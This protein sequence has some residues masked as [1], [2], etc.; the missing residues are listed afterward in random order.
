MFSQSGGLWASWSMSPTTRRGRR[1]GS[2]ELR[3]AK[4]RSCNPFPGSP[5]ASM[6]PTPSGLQS[7]DSRMRVRYF[8]GDTSHATASLIMIEGKT[9]TDRIIEVL[10]KAQSAE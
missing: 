9:K 5:S 1:C 3:Q 2:K 10:K 4:L 8:G 6:R 7:G